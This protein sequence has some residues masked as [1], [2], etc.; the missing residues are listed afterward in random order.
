MKQVADVFTVDML[1]PP[2]RGR[3]RPANPN[4]LTAAERKKAQRDR[5][6]AEGRVARTI[7]LSLE[8]VAALDRYVEAHGGDKN[9]LVDRLLRDRLLRKR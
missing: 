6:A 2:K 4:A 3:G 5:Q 7:F 9:T 1:P 8:V